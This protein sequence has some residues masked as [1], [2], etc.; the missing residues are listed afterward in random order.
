[1][2]KKTPATPKW[3][4]QKP[5]GGKKRLIN[6]EVT[7]FIKQCADGGIKLDSSTKLIPGFITHLKKGNA[8]FGKI[9]SSMQVTTYPFIEYLR[10][11]LR[12]AISKVQKELD[13]TKAAKDKTAD[14]AI[15]NPKS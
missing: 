1:M 14:D 10:L 9:K 13:A 7:S 11:Q 8:E 2:T 15:S 12:H 4:S 3:L 6:S 5:D